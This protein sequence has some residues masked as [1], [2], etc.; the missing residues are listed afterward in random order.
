M[1]RRRA[2]FLYSAGWRTAG[3]YLWARLR[4]LPGVTGFYEPLHEDLAGLTPAGIAERRADAWESGHPEM[5]PY[6]AEFAPLLRPEGGV[7]GYRPGFAVDRL[8][9]PEAEALVAY[10]GGLI[11]AAE[12]AGGIAVFKFCRASLRFA[13]LRRAFPQALHLAVDRNPLSQFASAWKQWVRFRNPYFLASPLLV[14]ARNQETAE[15]VFWRDALGCRPDAPGGEAGAGDHPSLAPLI[16]AMPAA[17]LYRIFLAHWGLI[18]QGLAGAEILATE[19]LGADPAA[20]ARLARRLR[21]AGAPAADFSDMRLPDR[22]GP[23]S[24]LKAETGLAPEDLRTI[25]DAAERA[26]RRALPGLA[27]ALTARL[28]WG[29]A[30]LTLRARGAGE[31]GFATL[32][33]ALRAEG[34]RLFRAGLLGRIGLRLPSPPRGR[35]MRRLLAE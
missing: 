8:H 12:R 31:A 30:L 19:L 23:A 16:A 32:A 28:A 17:A 33:G 3:T 14:L 27:A 13:L 9:E 2:V 18:H 5:A 22:P 7:L 6:F 11:A 20:R 24:P 15:G 29:E 25:H 21:R 35:L 10:L 4:S 1:G 26:F 34:R